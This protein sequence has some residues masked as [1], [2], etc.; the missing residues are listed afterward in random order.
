M[1]NVVVMEG[2]KTSLI[3]SVVYIYCHKTGTILFCVLGHVR[4]A[5]VQLLELV[6]ARLAFLSLLFI[7]EVDGF[8]YSS[9]IIINTRK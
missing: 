4:R 3:P 9:S 6:L 5:S 7:L 1:A 8:V 2:Q